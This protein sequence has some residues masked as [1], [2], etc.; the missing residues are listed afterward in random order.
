VE[1]GCD[2]WDQLWDT[3]LNRNGNSRHVGR[4]PVL[5]YVQIEAGSSN[6]FPGSGGKNIIL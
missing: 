1:C 3:L 5:E 2:K 6:I 4:L